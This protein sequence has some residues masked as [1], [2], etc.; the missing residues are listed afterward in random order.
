MRKIKSNRALRV[1]LAIAATLATGAGAVCLFLKKKAKKNYIKMSG[2]ILAALV[3]SG[4]S[5]TS[6]ATELPREPDLSAILTPV[7]TPTPVFPDETELIITGELKEKSDT[8][9][10]LEPLSSPEPEKTLQPDSNALTPA[11]N[12]SLVDDFSSVT[13][14]GKQFITVVTKS[15]AYFYIVIDRTKD[16]ENVYFLNLVDEADLLAIMEKDK[17]TAP[18]TPAP[19]QPTP[20]P[21]PA[22]APEPK[23]NN[24][25]MLLIVLLLVGALGGGAYYYFKVLKPKQGEKKGNTTELDDFD[26]DGDEDDFNDEP[27]KAEPDGEDDIPDFVIHDETADTRPESG[28]GE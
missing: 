11:G 13:A 22:P 15:G 7:V 6:Y 16:R 9:L 24:T 21:T 28:G 8:Q 19:V 17:K 14:I 5:M 1:I 4:L 27:D 18:T 2:F 26:F 10:V 12:L 3:L 20:E 23:Q 25:G